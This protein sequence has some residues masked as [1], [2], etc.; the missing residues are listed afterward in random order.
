MFVAPCYLAFGRHLKVPV[1][2]TVASV[3][4]D[5]LNQM[6]GNPLNLAYIPSFFSIY[7]QRMNFQERL[8]NFLLSHYITWQ[9]HYYT[10]S[11]TKIVKEHFGMDLSH[12]EELYNDVALYLVN[13]HYSL[14]G[15]RPM[16]TNVIEVGGLHLR[17]DDKPLSPVRFN[18]SFFSPSF[19]ARFSPNV[20]GIL[21]IIFFFIINVILF[22]FFFRLRSNEKLTN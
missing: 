10:N 13:S 9:M 11:Q 3:F 22:V 16:T 14:N 5:W 7:D 1:V 21:E 15:I 8:T 6:S 2:G 20:I 12:I 4:H 18:K 17:D 19:T